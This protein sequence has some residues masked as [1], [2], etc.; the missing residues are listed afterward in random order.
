MD[1]EKLKKQKLLKNEIID[2]C[3]DQTAFIEFC[4]QQKKNGDDLDSW[5]YDELKIVINEFINKINQELSLKYND[6]ETKTKENSIKENDNGENITNEENSKINKDNENKKI[7]ENDSNDEQN[8]ISEEKLV[9]IKCKLLKKNVL[10]DKKIKVT[11]NKYNYIKSKNILSESYVL[12]NIK[13]FSKQKNDKNNKNDNSSK[14]IV[15]FNVE[16]K[17]ID[18]LQLRE[19]LSKYFPYN[20]IPSLPEKTEEYLLKEENQP[21]IISYLQLFLN[22]IISKEELK[23]YE[24]IFSFLTIKDYN[25]YKN[26]LKEITSIPPPLNVEDTFSLEGTKTFQELNDDDYNNNEMEIE[27]NQNELQ[28]FNIKNYFEIQYK[29]IAQLKDHLK[30]FNTNFNNCFNN[31]GKIEQDF[32]FLYQLNNKVMMKESIKKSF[33][34]LGRFFQGWKDLIKKQNI[35]VKKN[36]SFFYNFALHE[37]LSYVSLIKKRENI[38]NL[39]ISEYKKLDQKKEKIWRNEDIKKWEI[40]YENFNV[41]N[42]LLLKD[43]KYAK[44]KMLYKETKEFEKIKNNFEYINH[45][46]KTELDYFLNNYLNGFK[47]FIQNFVKEF[48]PTLNDFINSWSSLSVFI[49]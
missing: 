45:T 46:Y 10:N 21:K 3:Y 35:L 36:I 32:T 1:E 41:D 13:L 43:K 20:Y 11:I 47:Y 42:A 2:R 38:K 31:L 40:N 29:L 27:E 12:Y 44:S 30:E 22:S 34:E 19:I 4:M 26:K 48:Y 14:E 23:A 24:L 7:N 28:F 16:R 33:Q 39:F 6:E 49:N 5:T 25:E 37:S 18:F 17:Y 9:T 15:D 8:N